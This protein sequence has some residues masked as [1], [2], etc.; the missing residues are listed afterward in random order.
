MTVALVTAATTDQPIPLAPLFR[1]ARD[2]YT[3]VERPVNGTSLP[4]LPPLPHLS[5]DDVIAIFSQWCVTPRV[6]RLIGRAITCPN[7]VIVCPS[8]QV[9]ICLTRAAPHLFTSDLQ[10][11]Q[12]DRSLVW[13]IAA[14][15]LDVKRGMAESAREAGL[16]EV[17]L[18]DMP[19][20]WTLLVA[21]AERDLYERSLD[22]RTVSTISALVLLAAVECV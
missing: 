3:A 18:P 5:E 22:D 9:R 12:L 1:V 21:H 4:P 13:M 10:S 15:V 11:G 17:D 19:C 14:R 8:P 2:P 7:S 20:H 6:A 16:P